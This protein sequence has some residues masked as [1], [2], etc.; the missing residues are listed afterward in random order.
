MPA[1]EIPYYG[2]DLCCDDRHQSPLKAAWLWMVTM[3]LQLG[4]DRKI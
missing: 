3:V 4:S 1:L 2:S